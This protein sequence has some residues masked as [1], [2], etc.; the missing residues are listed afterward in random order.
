MPVVDHPIYGRRLTHAE[1]KEMFGD[2]SRKGIVLAPGGGVKY[3]YATLGASSKYKNEV[4][5]DVVKYCYSPAAADNMAMDEAFRRGDSIPVKVVP[6]HGT[7]TYYWGHGKI[8][9]KDDVVYMGN[10]PRNRYVIERVTSP[11]ELAATAAS[12]PSAA[13]V[14]AEEESSVTL[15]S[16]RSTAGKRRI[17]EDDDNDDNADKEDN[18]TERARPAVVA[19][20]E[21]RLNT[22]TLVP[23]DIVRAI[24]EVEF[25]SLL[26]KRHAAMMTRLGLR[27]NRVPPT[28]HEVCLSDGTMHSY[29]PD[30]RVLPRIRPGSAKPYEGEEARPFV[31]EIK[32]RYPYDDEIRKCTETVAQLGTSV[33]LFYGGSPHF[34]MPFDHRPAVSGMQGSYAHADGVRGIRFSWEET[35]QSVLLEHDVAYMARTDSATGEVHAY[36]GVRRGLDE[37]VYHPKVQEAFEIASQVS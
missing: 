29:N 1:S 24:Q 3:V 11:E 19:R 22:R 36:V 4:T 28:I 20:V 35:S 5:R 25:D 32:P 31:I 33:V 8:V 2:A 7:D 6:N 13:P 18:N 26:E 15:R 14:E 34:G 17:V 9:S 21:N 10:C 30:F 23:A 16:T 27:W 12:S 37:A